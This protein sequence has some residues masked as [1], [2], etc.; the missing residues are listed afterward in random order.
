MAWLES[1]AA[2]QGALEEELLTKPEERPIETPEWIQ[3]YTGEAIEEPDISD[4]QAPQETEPVASELIGTVAA[5]LVAKHVYDEEIVEE[6]VAGVPQ[7]ADWL[8]EE[9]AFEGDQVLLGVE[10]VAFAEE[11]AVN[12]GIEPDEEA[13]FV[14]I[15]DAAAVSASLTKEPFAEAEPVKTETMEPPIEDVELPDWLRGLESEI[16]APTPEIVSGEWAPPAEFAELESI[17]TETED[18]SRI[19]INAASLTQ[20]ERIPGIGFIVAQSIV[21]YREVNG[22]FTSLEQL[23]EIPGIS[24]E[25]Y[26]ELN[27]KLVVETV[28]EFAPSPPRDPELAQAWQNVANGNIPA[29]VEQYS[30]FIRGNQ[31]LSEVITEIQEALLIYPLDPLLHQTLGDAYLRSDRLPEAM[32]AYNR[33]E[34]LL[35]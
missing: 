6:P 5:G 1:L 19:D 23:Q 29:A 25:T 10:P 32:E 22:P 11:E 7:P 34:D 16:V 26:D 8:P 27:R 17:S 33:A 31:E 4:R 15:L 14:T 35:K 2:R 30:I 13:E 24:P 28:A 3:Q 18:S 12:T 21:A 20:L 9:S